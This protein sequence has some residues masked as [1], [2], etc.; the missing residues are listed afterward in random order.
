MSANQI[1]F[2]LLYLGIFLL[3]GKWLRVKTKWLQNLFLPSSIIGGF[4]A[5]LLGPEVL[6]KILGL[7]TDSNFWT[8]GIIPEEVINVWD[9]LPGLM[10]SIVFATL[11][12]GTTIPS[13]SKIWRLA[14]PQLSFGWTMG[15]GQYVV[16]VLLAVLVLTPF[17][18][19]P[20]MAGALIEIAFEGGH[21][22]A[23]GMAGTFEKLDFAEAYDLSIGLATVGLLSG[24]V[25]GIILI[26]W[27]VRKNKTEVVKNVEGF[28]TLKKQG[29]MEYENREPAASMTV[30]P[31]SIEPLSLHFAIV[32][33]AVIV[34]YLLL[35]FLIWLE[36]VTWGTLI[37]SA[38][39]EYIPLF[40]L[41]MIGGIILQVFFSKVDQAQIVDRQ[42][43]NRIQGFAL[44]VLII[45]AIGT[46]SLDVIGEYLVPF[47]LLALVGI[48]WN[49]FGILVLAPRMIP[50][51]WFERSIGDFGQSMGVTATG[52]LLMRVVDPNNETPAFESFGYK[53]LVYEPFLG[54]GLIT[55]LSVPLIFQFGPWPFLIFSVVMCAVGLLSGLLFFGK[56]SKQRNR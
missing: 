46:I 53:Q 50:T 31:E 20:P 55:A 3:I 34:G 48:I 11:F 13:L 30:R 16:G 41:A 18:N 7:F 47:V 4:V 5:L 23:A 33:F 12:L 32:G 36:S 26:N 54:G 56:K 42:M 35:Q 21:G 9:T 6:G 29:I 27:A 19:I 38:L 24:L 49:V 25:I 37:D 51:Y 52:L 15:W 1:G 14:G 10:I 8:N 40:P 43:I 39:M 2:A 17:F 44:D 22:T 45:S 28:S